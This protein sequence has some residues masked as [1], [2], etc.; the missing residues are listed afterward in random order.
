MTDP[1]CC[2]ACLFPP[3]TSG[4]K[5]TMIT[6]IILQQLRLCHFSPA[7]TGLQTLHCQDNCQGKVE[8]SPPRQSSNVAGHPG[9]R[10]A[11]ARRAGKLKIYSSERVCPMHAL[12]PVPG[13]TGGGRHGPTTGFGFRFALKPLL[14][15]TVPGRRRLRLGHCPEA[16]DPR[17]NVRCG[18]Q[19]L[20][21]ADGRQ[22]R[23][24]SP[25]ERKL[26]ATSPSF[27]Y[28]SPFAPQQASPRAT[29]PNR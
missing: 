10:K 26:R 18:Y 8:T 24:P 16:A 29:L 21:S 2:C 4:G 23:P 25:G 19:P 27:G 28:R 14:T 9:L 13:P 15:P 11:P 20:T 6:S 5:P 1:N 7:V 3:C 22:R 12:L 17:A